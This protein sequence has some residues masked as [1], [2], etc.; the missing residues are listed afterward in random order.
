V[1]GISPSLIIQ[2]DKA[3]IY[4]PGQTPA[5]NFHDHAALRFEGLTILE[6]DPHTNVI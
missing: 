3:I 6:K 1:I 2:P 5:T 4:M